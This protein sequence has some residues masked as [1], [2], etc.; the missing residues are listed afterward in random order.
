MT[1]DWTKEPWSAFHNSVQALGSVDTHSAGVWGP[2]AHCAP[3]QES[4]VESREWFISGDSKANARRIASCV[5]AFEGIPDPAAFVAAAGKAEQWLRAIHTWLLETDNDMRLPDGIL[6]A[7]PLDIAEDLT[8]AR[9][10]K[11]K[12]TRD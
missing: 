10:A 4:D 9:A 2:V 6:D 1:Q 5:N 8:A 7:N 12:A 11:G 3:L